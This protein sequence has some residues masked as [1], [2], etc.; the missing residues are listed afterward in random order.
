MRIVLFCFVLF[1]FIKNVFAQQEN[2]H[3]E[4]GQNASLQFNNVLPYNP[5]YN[6]GLF[7]VYTAGNNSSICDIENGELLIY[8]HGGIIFNKLGVPMENGDSI[9]SGKYVLQYYPNGI[10][11]YQGTLILPYPNR[12]NLYYVFYTNLDSAIQ[13][14]YLASKFRY[15]IV[16]MTLNNGLGKVIDK[17]KLI[18]NGLFERGRINAIHHANG[19]D[20]WIII[21]GYNDL[22][23]YIYLLSPSGLKLY[24]KQSI[25][26]TYNCVDQ[27]QYQT[28]TNQS[29][30]QIAYLYSTE[31]ISLTQRID[32]YD[33][34]RCTGL[35][36]NYKTISV[37]DTEFN[38]LSFSP[39]DSL[40]YANNLFK[41]Y[42]FNIKDSTDTAKILIDRYNGTLDPFQVLFGMQKI[43][44]DN[45][46]YMSTWN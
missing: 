14:S 17:D 6:R 18:E 28:C 16:D 41:L 21:N 37:I 7:Y 29:G 23:H 34:D 36:S 43:A 46:I 44:P 35:L 42:Q 22:Q 45:K 11:A 30:N 9:N 3:W 12:P 39:N 13:G 4:L 24:S 40:L 32:L 26:S 5:N 27:R 31:D 15:S 38:G 19:R 20:W 33:F 2:F 25:G 10:I 1:C 8:C